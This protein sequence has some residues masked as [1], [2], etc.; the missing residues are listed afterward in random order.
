M[1]SSYKNAYAVYEQG[2]REPTL[3][4]I[5]PLLTAA[6]PKAERPVPLYFGADPNDKVGA[7]PTRRPKYQKATI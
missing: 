1:G 3:H 2:K 6:N 4:S 5:A 7:K